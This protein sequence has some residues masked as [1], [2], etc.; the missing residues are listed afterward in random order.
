MS[1]Y[2]IGD[3]HGRYDLFVSLLNKISFCPEKD[4]LYILGDIIDG[5]YGGIQI[6]KY[7]MG[8]QD[9]VFLIQGNHEQFFLRMESLYD[10]AMSTEEI[11]SA[12]YEA[13]NVYSKDLFEPISDC[14][15]KLISK[16]RYQA[17]YSSSTIKRWL[18]NGNPKVRTDLLDAMVILVNRLDYDIEKY[19]KMFRILSNLRGH[20]KTKPFVQELLKQSN[21]EYEAIKSFLKSCPMEYKLSLNGKNYFLSHS[22]WDV[23]KNV[24]TK[25]IFPHAESSNT[26]YIYG[27]DPVPMIHRSLMDCYFNWF[28]FDYRRVFAWIDMENNRYYNLDLGSNP[29]AA[30]K[31]EDMSE[32]YVG[33][34]STRKNSKPWIVPDDTFQSTGDSYFYTDDLHLGDARWV[35]TSL[36]SL[37]DGCFEFLICLS[38]R[39]KIY[40]THIGCSEYHRAFVIENPGKADPCEVI[41]LVRE[42]FTIQRTKPEVQW[43]YNIL[44][45]RDH[46][47]QCP[48]N[49]T[50]T[51]C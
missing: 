44:Y 1:I 45:G 3:L 48:A 29:I 47:Q 31:L 15:K 24:S 46:Q 14:F 26:T 21:A 28:D 23:N 22:K 27:H 18:E 30:L 32:Y 34:P 2:C 38:S 19:N 33:M 37:V 43:V 5:S 35:K 51:S 40:Y 13:V 11:K 36:V 10:L 8:H 20:F 42:D 25:W 41:Q 6:L 39:K 49:P 4:K 16:K 50:D 12:M 9:S 17:F 7:I